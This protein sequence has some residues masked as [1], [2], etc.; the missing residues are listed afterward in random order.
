MYYG[1]FQNAKNDP[2]FDFKT[3]KMVLFFFDFH[4]QY[5][6]FINYWKFITHHIFFSKIFKN[7]W[8]GIFEIIRIFESSNQD[9]KGDFGKRSFF[10]KPKWFHG[11][12]KFSQLETT[13]DQRWFQAILEVFLLLL[14]N[15]SIAKKPKLGQN[16]PYVGFHAV[17]WA[18]RW[19]LIFLSGF[20]IEK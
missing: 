20:N 2:F 9:F 4:S 17:F 3:L 19:Y 15:V 6:S 11:G 1:V 14:E 18:S 16:S 8:Y 5:A 7:I 13:F 12:F 10:V